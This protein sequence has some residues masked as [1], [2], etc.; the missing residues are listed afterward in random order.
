MSRYLAVA[1][2]ITEQLFHAVSVDR[3]DA[4]KSAIASRHFVI[5]SVRDVRLHAVRTFIFFQQQ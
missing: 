3:R 1:T 5:V 4:A 2:V